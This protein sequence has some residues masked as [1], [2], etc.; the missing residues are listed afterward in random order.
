METP[1]LDGDRA[2]DIGSERNDSQGDSPRF[3]VEIYAW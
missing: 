2:F 1:A 3:D